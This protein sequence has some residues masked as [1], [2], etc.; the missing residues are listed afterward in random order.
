MREPNACSRCKFWDQTDIYGP[1]LSDPDHLFNDTGYC[2]RYPPPPEDNPGAGPQIERHPIT[3]SD[4][5]CGEF[6]RA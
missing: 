3:G 1:D 5:W 2:R 6:K 4:L